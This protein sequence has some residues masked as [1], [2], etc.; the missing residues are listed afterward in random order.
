MCSVNS[1]S[2]DDTARSVTGPI[3][4]KAFGGAQVFESVGF[5]QPAGRRT[6]RVQNVD[7]FP[8]VQTVL[9]G[10]GQQVASQYAVALA[11]RTCHCT[12]EC[13]EGIACFDRGLFGNAG[14][15]VEKADGMVVA[16]NGMFFRGA[17]LLV[18]VTGKDIE[19][20]IE[21]RLT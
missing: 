15:G 13:D 9:I 16:Q 10:E 11:V 17:E 1:K 5:Q 3:R 2:V 7:L 14:H 4:L 12:F 20:G 8:V 18:H 19:H 6:F 21:M